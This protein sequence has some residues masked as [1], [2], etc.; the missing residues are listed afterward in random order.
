MS[1]INDIAFDERLAVLEIE[2]T[3]TVGGD[4]LLQ[5]EFPKM[6]QKLAAL[7]SSIA[8]KANQS[9][10]D[11][12]EVT[13]NTKANR[14]DLDIALSLTG[15]QADAL[16][17]LLG[18]KA[19]QSDVDAELAL[20]ANQTDVALT[21]EVPSTTDILNNTNVG[22]TAVGGAYASVNV[23]NKTSGEGVDFNFTIPP[24]PQGA[25][26]DTG[27]TGPEGPQGPNGN[28][29]ATGLDTNGNLSI[30]GSI[31]ATG[32]ITAFSDRRLKSEIERI[33]GG[34]EKVSKINGYT[35]IQNNKRSTGC[36]AQEVMEVLPEAVLEVYNGT[37]EETLYTL[38]YGNLAGL[39][40]EAIKELKGEL[41][42]LKKK[43]GV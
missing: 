3:L 32:D 2:G 40:V 43:V 13:L 36:V 25:K 35:Y 10:M 28:T 17:V 18:T 34:L 9:D 15:E 27:A 6:D 31:T 24:G 8:L 41:D 33:E 4:I 21:T 20:K 14:S 29:G 11:E 26:G 1:F 5:G 23:V 30:N 38:A 16:N 12:L 39:F 37:A 7:N 22:A 19:N 42:A